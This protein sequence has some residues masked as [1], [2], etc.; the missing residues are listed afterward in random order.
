MITVLIYV[1]TSQGKEILSITVII[2]ITALINI[3]TTDQGRAHIT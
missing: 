3:I 2:T 1:L